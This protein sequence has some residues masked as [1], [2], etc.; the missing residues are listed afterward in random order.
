[1]TIS[2]IHQVALECTAGSSDKLYII[3]I[4][5]D[6][7][8]PVPQ[9][10]TVA[11]NGRR[12]AGLTTQEKYAWGPDKA[13]AQASATRV[14]NDKRRGKG[15]SAYSDMSLA[16]GA[17][18][19]GIPAGT[20]VFGGASVAAPSTPAPAIPVATG[21]GLKL[22]KDI[23]DAQRKEFHSSPRWGMQR[24]Y[25]GNR[26]ALSLRRDAVI[27][28]N[29]RGM[30][31]SVSAVVEASVKSLLS[32]ADF[33]N[34]RETVLDGEM[35][36]DVYVAFDIL[37]LRDNPQHEIPLEE[38]YSALE[39]LLEDNLGLLAKTAFTQKEKDEMRAEG[40]R[41]Y[42]EGF[43]YLDLEAGYSVGRSASTFKDKQ[44][45]EAT[46]RVLTV[47]PTKRSVQIGLRNASD[48]ELPAG[49]VTIPVNANV[50]E[51]D[52]LI[53][54]KYLYALPDGALY[55]P[56]FKEVRHDKDECDLRSSIRSA[57][58][59]K[60]GGS[61]AATATATVTP[62]SSPPTSVSGSATGSALAAL[63]ASSPVPE[64]AEAEVEDI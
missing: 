30:P 46:C 5:E 10:Q 16:P 55:Q 36:G 33:N 57:P 48:E 7:S 26:C 6:T 3:Q 8:G 62:T 37:T 59:E 32:R 27:A 53:E 29:R 25:D 20:P 64:P 63:V 40:E 24:K 23:S 12:G 39:I 17:V 35:M 44:W 47:N 4:H 50:P 28:Y 22:A 19:P 43:M 45:A 61:A 52:D 34:D 21:P 31:V 41:D 2:C 9:Y 56:V 42:W 58:P 38:R 18:P 15:S 60:T 51:P 54:V 11:F 13:T 1:M 14:E 49:N